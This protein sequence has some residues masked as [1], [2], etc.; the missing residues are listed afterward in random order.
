MDFYKLSLLKCGH[1]FLN[2]LSVR[3]M[4]PGNLHLIEVSRYQGQGTKLF[5]IVRKKN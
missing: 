1:F 2:K 5:R 4:S 3:E